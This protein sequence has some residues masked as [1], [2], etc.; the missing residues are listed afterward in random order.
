MLLEGC[1]ERDAAQCGESGNLSKYTVTAIAAQLAVLSR[2]YG[3]VAH[4]P[5]RIL[6]FGGTPT[7]ERRLI[8]SGFKRTGTR[9]A[10]TGVELFEKILSWPPH[11]PKDLMTLGL[12][13]MLGDYADDMPRPP[14]GDPD[15]ATASPNR[16][17]S[18]TLRY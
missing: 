1:A 14:H 9:M 2:A 6:T 7:N 16:N 18:T 11:S 3:K 13:H 15:A 12:F 5:L 10:N 17:V 8:S 4:D